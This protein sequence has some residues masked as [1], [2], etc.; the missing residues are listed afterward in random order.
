MFEVQPFG[1]NFQKT[2]QLGVA[3]GLGSIFLRAD[4]TGFTFKSVDR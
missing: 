4:F 2:L 3:T 1:N